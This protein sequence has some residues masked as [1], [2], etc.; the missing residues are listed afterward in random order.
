MLSNRR[1]A[2]LNEAAQRLAG[3]AL[4]SFTLEPP[5]MDFSGLAKL[6]GLTYARAS[7]EAELQ[8]S[9]AALKGKLR[10]STL[11]E[12][13]LDPALKPVTASRHF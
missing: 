8:S 13:V 6:Y 12:L 1:Y 10:R 11:L 7:T 4:D 3:G 5:V 2:T 9:V